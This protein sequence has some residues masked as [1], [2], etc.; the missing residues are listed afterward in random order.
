MSS[1]CGHTP[2]TV[3][4]QIRCL[5][6]LKSACIYKYSACAVS[7][8]IIDFQQMRSKLLIREERNTCYKCVTSC[9][10]RNEMKRIR[11]S[12]LLQYLLVTKWSF[13]NSIH[14]SGFEQLLG[15]RAKI[16]RFSHDTPIFLNMFLVQGNI[17][18][19]FLLVLQA[20]FNVDG[21]QQ[22]TM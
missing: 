4:R 21:V 11:F 7:Y 17:V 2:G 3:L 1:S 8:D 9:I 18:T 12:V 19:L 16:V 6:L 20:Y 15:T 5:Y 10:E 14:P 22:D 13:C